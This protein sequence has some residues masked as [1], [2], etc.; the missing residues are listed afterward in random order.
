MSVVRSSSF[1]IAL[2]LP[3]V[4]TAQSPPPPAASSTTQQSAAATEPDPDLLVNPAEPDFTLSALPTTLRMPSGKF[5]FRLTHRFSRPIASGSVGDF[6]ADLFGFDSSAQ[7]GLELRYGLRPGTQVAVHR[8]NDRTIQFL[9]QHQILNQRTGRPFAL[10]A[11]V[12]VEGADNFSEDFSTTVGAVIS[13]QF[14]QHGAV[15]V[16]PLFVFN[17]NPVEDGDQDTMLLGFGTRYRLF[18]S[19]TYIVFEAAP[20]VSG[21][22]AGIDH[23]SFGFEHRVGGHMFQLT[24]ANAL[25]TTMRQI[26]LGGPHEDDW[27]IGFN[28]S[29]RF[30]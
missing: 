29:R 17:T 9:G 30:F 25:G 20:V 23:V 21:H 24:I 8:T 13:R 15:Y 1:V 4:A 14:T 12:S 19:R 18:K 22:D 27:F 5:A 26:A 16:Q 2:L 6:F 28:L 11:L 7:I 3:S 10:D